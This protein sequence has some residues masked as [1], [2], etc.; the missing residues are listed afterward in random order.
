MKNANGFGSVYKMSGRRRRPYRAVITVGYTPDGKQIRQTLGYYEQKKEALSALGLYHSEPYNLNHLRFEDIYNLW[1]EEKFKEISESSARGYQNAFRHSYSLHRKYFRDLRTIDLENCI[2]SAKVT[3][4]IQQTMKTLFLQLYKYAL[5]YDYATRN[6]A[7]EIKVAPK[8]ETKKR[9]PFSDK[10]I[11]RLWEYIEEPHEENRIEAAKMI[12]VGIYSGWRPTELCTF[13]LLKSGIMKGGVKTKAG[14]NRVVP[15]HPLIAGFVQEYDMP[16]NTYQSR[17]YALVK[18][19]GWKHT[20][21]DTRRTFATLASRAKMDEN[22]RKLI[23]GH[24]NPDLTERVYTT[25][26][27]EEL[28]EEMAKIGRI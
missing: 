1:S 17:F 21:H 10:E 8:K 27:V 28:K 16:Y 3:P 20:P 2:K 15:V 4:S 6:Y 11:L 26:T 13:K 5:R 25:H 12:L 24:S 9:R 18:E 23:L 14:K 19:L 22:I 7:E